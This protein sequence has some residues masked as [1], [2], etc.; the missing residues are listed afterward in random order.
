MT[1]TQHIPQ[2]SECTHHHG[3]RDDIDIGLLLSLSV[4]R[5]RTKPG[6]THG[7]IITV[8]NTEQGGLHVTLT[9]GHPCGARSG[10]RRR[11]LLRRDGRSTSTRT[12]PRCATS[13]RCAWCLPIDRRLLDTVVSLSQLRFQIRLLSVAKPY[14]TSARCSVSESPT[15]NITTPPCPSQL[16]CR[17]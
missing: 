9:N 10:R 17:L 1:H 7:V 8:T 14:T 13:R 2:G 5:Q 16:C 6:L 3:L 12:L 11:R 4:Y 15:I